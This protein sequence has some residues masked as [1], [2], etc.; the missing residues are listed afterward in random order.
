MADV[1][2][3]ALNL[4]PDTCKPKFATVY[5]RQA[6]AI[7]ES[8]RVNPEREADF[9]EWAYAVQADEGWA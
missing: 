9:W 1:R 2:S 5:R 4:V 8:S 7:A 3:K 6:L